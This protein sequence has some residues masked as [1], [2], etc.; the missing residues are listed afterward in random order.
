MDILK[1]K[2][3][4]FFL[5]IFIYFILITSAFFI[6]QYSLKSVSLN[7][8]IAEAMTV[9]GSTDLAIA[10]LLQKL[11]FSLYEGATD[12]V[13]KHQL[14]VETANELKNQAKI[15]TIIFFIVAAVW[16][17][18]NF[19]VSKKEPDQDRFWRHVLL[20]SILSLLIGLI[21]PM[22]QMTAY[23]ELPLLGEVVFKYEAK[24]IF[25]TVQSLFS[26]GNL[27]IAGLITLLSIFVPL[28]KMGVVSMNL[29]NVAP[30]LHKRAH[31]LIHLLGKWS[32]A[33]VFVVAIL[34]SIFALDTQDF[35]RAESDLGL[36]FFAA[37]CL[38]SLLVTHAVL[39]ET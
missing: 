1:N 16:L 10:E 26:H 23:K 6:A 28:L 24:S 14:L 31:D 3:T 36:Y 39:K 20:I 11:S 22:M 12:R 5:G 4:L 7:T 30:T 32:M 34:I 2:N 18:L 8:Q 35:T 25:S 38:L 33:D 19:F 29:F 13:A 17:I 15:F 21:A 27:I 9:E 37:Y